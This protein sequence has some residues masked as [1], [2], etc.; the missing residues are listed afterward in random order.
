MLCQTISTAIEESTHVP[1]VGGDTMMS[2][3]DKVVT[4]SLLDPSTRTFFRPILAESGERISCRGGV[5]I[6]EEVRGV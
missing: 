4:D 6:V 1:G 2:R 5:V 3:S